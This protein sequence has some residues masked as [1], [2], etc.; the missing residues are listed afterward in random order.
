MLELLMV[1]GQIFFRGWVF[2]LEKIFKFPAKTLIFRCPNCRQ[3]RT[4]REFTFLAYS[5]S[6]L[7][8]RPTRADFILH[9]DT[10]NEAFNADAFF[11]DPHG[12]RQLKTWDCPTCSAQ[13][14]NST[15]TCLKCGYA[16]I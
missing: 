14:P 12:I 10:C 16:L 15:F 7:M 4:G 13:N 1:L 3:N 6:G 2:L 8:R 9:C 11:T 5:K